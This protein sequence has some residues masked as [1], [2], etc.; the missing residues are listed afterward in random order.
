MKKL[1]LILLTISFIFFMLNN[2][3]D[4]SNPTITDAEQTQLHKRPS[5]PEITELW[6]E[7]YELEKNVPG[8]E[9]I[10]HY[11][12]TNAKAVDHIIISFVYDQN[13]DNTFSSLFDPY[14]VWE[15]I[16]HNGTSEISG[17]FLWNGKVLPDFSA[18]PEGYLFDQLATDNPDKY[19]LNF[20][21]F[22]R[23]CYATNSRYPVDGNQ[24]VLINPTNSAPPFSVE[25]IIIE[26]RTPTKKKDA[27]TYSKELFFYVTCIFD[28]AENIGFKG[29]GKWEAADGG[30]IAC[31]PNYEFDSHGD[32]TASHTTGILV[33]SGTYRFYVKDVHSP[34][35]SY[36]PSG[37]T[38]DGVWPDEPYGEITIE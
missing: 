1:I 18:N 10:V 20:S 19:L 5:N 31:C 23:N 32:I 25:S 9:I 3:T 24:R 29:A 6:I 7:N 26:S 36:N 37:N 22:G 14:V 15:T 4:S 34:Y 28:G 11:K 8:D 30:T 16:E 38:T 12:V 35:Y 17:D 33:T 27:K 2:C 21:V 13:N